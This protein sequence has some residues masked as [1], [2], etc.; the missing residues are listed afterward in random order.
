M[1]ERTRKGQRED[2]VEEVMNSLCFVLLFSRP[3]HSGLVRGIPVIGFTIRSWQTIVIC[4]CKM[5]NL[6]ALEEFEGRSSTNA[7]ESP[8]LGLKM[9]VL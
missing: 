4:N 7:T 8:S 9:D 2:V 6:G 1:G 5:Q 3:Q